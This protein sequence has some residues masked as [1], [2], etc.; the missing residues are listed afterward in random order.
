MSLDLA[1]ITDSPPVSTSLTP[2]NWARKRLFNTWY[3]IILT[4]AALL[5]IGLG[6]KGFLVWATTQ[7]QWAVV[8][9]NLKL[10]VAGRF[11]DPLLWRLWIILGVII[12]LSGLTWGKLQAKE[13][14]WTRDRLL[15]AAGI[16][17][18]IGLI[19]ISFASRLISGGLLLLLLVAFWLGRLLP[20][21]FNRWLA[22]AWALSFP[23][24]FWLLR[25]GFGLQEVQTTDWSGLLLTLLGAV[26]GIAFAFPLG[27][28]L[29]LGRQSTL[30]IVRLF[31]TLFIEVM[32]GLPLIGVLFIGLVMLPLLLPPEWGQ[33][34]QLLR[35]LVGLILFSAAYIA[36]VVRGGLQSVPRGQLE[37]ARALGL[38]PLLVI[39]LILLPQ[40]LRTVIPALVGEFVSLFKETTLLSV[41]GLIEL[42]GISASIL[43]NPDYVGRYVE[44]YLFA[45][46]LYWIFCYVMSIASQRLE[47]S[48]GVDQ[49]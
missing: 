42:L 37:A 39:G 44:V 7:A 11:P 49:R 25:G 8:S 26:I 28:L 23:L 21:R 27:V 6:L 9:N 1:P 32:R 43:A 29:A 34:D 14:L 15:I 17:V 46:G 20:S 30:P 36:E 3:N 35:G 22:V 16:A 10:F 33:P 2:W 41:F 38:N 24:V 5:A 18:A 45:G 13:R 40:A 4:I 19:P 48:L 47:N 31:S 12:G